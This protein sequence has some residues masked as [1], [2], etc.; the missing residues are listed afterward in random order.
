MKVDLKLK[1]FPLTIDCFDISNIQGSNTVASCV[2]FKNGKPYKNGYRKYNIKTVNGPDDFAS[3]KEV[4]FRRYKRLIDEKKEL[5]NLIIVDGGKGQ[6]SSSVSALKSLKLEDIPVLGIAK[7]L[8]EIFYP[9]DPIPLYL[10]KRSETLKIIQHIRNEAHR[11]AITFHRNKRSIDALSSSLD[12]IP[13][14]GEKT[15]IYLL[16]KYRSLKNIREI[17]ESILAN[18]IGNARAKKLVSFFNS[19][20]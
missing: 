17:P 4:V 12:S 3:M 16:K 11:F 7:R 14:I 8:E 9:N 15:K 2:V 6:L 19:S 13:G 10:D 1:E 20:Q 5:P 18:D